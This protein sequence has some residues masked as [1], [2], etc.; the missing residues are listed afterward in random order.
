MNYQK[1]CEDTRKIVLQ[2]GDFIQ[3]Q[4]GK[5]GQQS[6]EEKSVNQ[7]VSYVDRTAEEMLVKGLREILP[8]ATFLTEEQTVENQQSELQWIIDPL[9]GTTNFLYNIPV[10]AV[11][12]ALQKGSEILVGVVYEINRQECFYAW[13]GGGAWLNEVAISVS[14][15]KTLE[16][17][18][19]A[20]G[21]PVD[22]FGRL[23]PHLKSVSY[24]IQHTRGLRR[25]G[26]AATDLAYVACGRFDVY[27]EYN[28]NAWDVAAGILLVLEAGGVVTDFSGSDNY[29]FGR[30]VVAAS[31]SV[32]GLALPV[33][34]Q[35]FYPTMPSV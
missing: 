16:Q 35:A 31:A 12:V 24:F 33:I 21:F 23:A 26:S 1:I 3:A 18:L 34:R 11:S 27:F 17:S 5:V 20:T 32:H 25:L 13:Q 8:A 9:D 2:A 28:I 29:L 14:K 19:V 6:V 4:L 22:S 7:L 30:E 15:T 10:F